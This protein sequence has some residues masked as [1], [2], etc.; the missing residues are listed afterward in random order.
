MT[1]YGQAKAKRIFSLTWG[2]NT[3]QLF[4]QSL[5]LPPAQYW[6]KGTLKSFGPE[7]VNVPAK[8]TKGEEKNWNKGYK[9]SGFSYVLPDKKF[10]KDLDSCYKGCKEAFE[11]IRTP[12]AATQGQ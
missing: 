9:C 7:K 2:G 11:F 8:E 10:S 3:F 5:M 6:K 4:D 12:Q 1:M